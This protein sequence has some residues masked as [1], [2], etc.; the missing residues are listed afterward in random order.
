MFCYFCPTNNTKDSIFG[1]TPPARRRFFLSV[2]F[3]D[4]YIANLQGYEKDPPNIIQTCL[5][6]SNGWPLWLVDFSLR[7]ESQLA[8]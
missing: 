1:L 3:T 5:T 6:I 7:D 4:Q 8:F 2:F